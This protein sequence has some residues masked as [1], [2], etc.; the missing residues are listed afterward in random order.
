MQTSVRPLELVAP[1][2]NQLVRVAQDED[3]LAALRSL[4]GSTH[5]LTSLQPV[6]VIEGAGDDSSGHTVADRRLYRALHPGFD[7]ATV[8]SGGGKRE[9]IALATAL[10]QALAGFAPSLRVVALLDRD[11]D[12][13]G[14]QV[15]KVLPVSMIENLLVDAEV[16]FEAIES[17]LDRT[18]FQTVDDVTNVLDRLLT[19]AEPREVGRRAAA[20]LGSAHFH[21]PSDVDAV[22]ERARQFLIEVQE[23]FSEGSVEAARTRSQEAVDAIRVA[24]RRREEFDGKKLLQDFFRQH[25]HSSTLSRQ[26]FM[27]YAARRARRR[28]SVIGFFDQFFTELTDW[29]LSRLGGLAARQ[30]HSANGAE[31]RS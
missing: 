17:V 8:I 15:V 13:G 21:P 30:Q 20:A 14:N 6:I 5:N 2:D 22:T 31:L 10:Q 26:V 11:F 3:R 4:F 28:R 23:R 16:L 19:D 1:E 9:C 18:T 24:Q 27:F 12:D 29:D 7:R 25:L